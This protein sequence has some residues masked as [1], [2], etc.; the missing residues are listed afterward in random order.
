MYIFNE[1]NQIKATK[2]EW[3]LGLSS[4]FNQTIKENICRR[5]VLIP[6][7]ILSF[8]RFQKKQITLVYHIV[9]SLKTI[10]ILFRG[11]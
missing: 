4:F 2:E 8:I 1:F 10:Y 9:S 6:P 7:I 11:I 3:T 5:I